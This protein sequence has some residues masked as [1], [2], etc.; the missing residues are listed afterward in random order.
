MQREFLPAVQLGR[1]GAMRITMAAFFFL[2]CGSML[3]EARYQA[4]CLDMDVVYGCN[5]KLGSCWRYCAPN[6]TKGKWCPIG[7]TVGDKC[8]R[9][10]CEIDRDCFK[11]ACTDDCCGVCM[12]TDESLMDA[13]GYEK[14][15]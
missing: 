6:Y 9:R 5:K 12:V 15:V 4:R 10:H 13:V 2:L 14:G 3:V 11:N 1:L 7:T 8:E